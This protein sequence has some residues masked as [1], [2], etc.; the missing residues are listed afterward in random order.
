MIIFLIIKLIGYIFFVVASIRV[1]FYGISGIFCKEPVEIKCIKTKNEIKYTYKYNKTK[2]DGIPLVF[3]FNDSS[4]DTNKIEGFINP[5]KPTKFY[6]KIKWRN[7]HTKNAILT[8]FT[9]ISTR[10]FISSFLMIVSGF[11]LWSIL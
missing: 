6:V 8:A 4:F 7:Q 2:Y 1:L 9:H 5:K 3:M 10:L 11:I